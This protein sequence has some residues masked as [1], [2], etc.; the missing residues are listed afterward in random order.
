MVVAQDQGNLCQMSLTVFVEYFRLKFCYS[1][2]SLDCKYLK[3]IIY[4]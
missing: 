3:I 4:L 1:Y 2:F